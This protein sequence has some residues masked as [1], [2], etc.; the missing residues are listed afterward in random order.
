MQVQ[1]MNPTDDD[2]QPPA[3]FELGQ[4]QLY[5]GLVA[6]VCVDLAGVTD[7]WWPDDDT[8]QIASLG[9][10]AAAVTEAEFRA[11][12]DADETLRAVRGFV[13]GQWPRRKEIDPAVAGFYQSARLAREPRSPYLRRFLGEYRATPH[14]ATGETP[15]RLMRGREARTTLDVLKRDAPTGNSRKRAVRRRHRRYQSAYKRSEG[16]AK[17]RHLKTV[18]RFTYDVIVGPPPMALRSAVAISER[19]KS[20]LHAPMDVVAANFPAGTNEHD[21]MQLFDR[22]EPLNVRIM[23]NNS[24]P[25]PD[26]FTYAYVT[27]SSRMMADEAV[28]EMDGMAFHGRPL[29]VETRKN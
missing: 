26:D 11:A 14:P 12:S 3:G 6:T 19:I 23:V 1:L 24:S 29:V 7:T 2:M 20:R 18:Q 4:T 8:I 5:E 22:F 9:V 13:A 21:L 16:V 15:F 27:L 10:A 28:M 17:L 25:H